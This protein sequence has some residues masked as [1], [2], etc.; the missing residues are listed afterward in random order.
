MPQPQLNLSPDADEL[1]N[2]RNKAVTSDWVWER[3]HGGSGTT[4]ARHQWD[5]AAAPTSEHVLLDEGL[6]SFGQRQLLHQ[7]QPHPLSDHE[8]AADERRCDLPR[9][10]QIHGVTSRNHYRQG[11]RPPTQNTDRS[12]LTHRTQT[13]GV[14]SHTHTP[15]TGGRDLPNRTDRCDLPH[16]IQTGVTSHTHQRQGGG[17]NLLHTLQAGGVTSHT[18][19]R[20]VGV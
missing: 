7:V 14:P 10:L 3:P 9:R 12:D 17:R 5:T 11:A 8:P 13:G 4:P 2:V 1:A 20:R 19:C 18:Y 16:T 15:Q 6:D